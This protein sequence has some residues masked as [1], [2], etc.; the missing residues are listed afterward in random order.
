MKCNVQ[1]NIVDCSRLALTR[2]PRH[3]PIYATSLDFS[4]NNITIVRAFTFQD[5]QNITE[6]H[7][8]L[9]GIQSI[10]KM[11][12]RGLYRLR[13][14]HL[15]GNSLKMLPSGVLDN[16]N[17]LQ[18]LSIDNNKLKG[19]Q[20]NQIKEISTILSLRTLSFD[21]YPNFQFP[22][23]WSTLSKLNRLDMIPKS[24]KSAIQQKNVRSYQNDAD[25]VFEL[26]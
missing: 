14:L 23:Q 18:Y 2:I 10:E 13:R 20:E 16:M 5:F 12:F 26:T 21:I 22:G 24:K 6:L 8:D 17:C 15:G 25:H 7:L 19:Y 3:L 11:A 9:N 4:R 1:N